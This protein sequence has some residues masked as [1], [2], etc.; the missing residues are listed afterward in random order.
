MSSSSST[1]TEHDWEFSKENAAPLEYGRSTKSLSKR[2]FGTS[3]S[4][5]VAIEE[6]TKKYEKLVRR[7][8]KAVE[9]MQKQSKKIIEKGNGGKSNSSSPRR[10][11]SYYGGSTH[12]GERRSSYNAAAASSQPTRK[13]ESIQ[14]NDII[15]QKDVPGVQ[16]K[17]DEQEVIHNSSSRKRSGVIC[18]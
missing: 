17:R 15:R 18:T 12:E 9:W 6:K 14:K 13:Y 8:E 16:S 10:D 11:Y 4:E 1:N 5:M 2:A 7:S 3:T